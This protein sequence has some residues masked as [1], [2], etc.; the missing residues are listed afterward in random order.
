MKDLTPKF[1]KKPCN[2]SLKV[3]AHFEPLK[4]D[5][6]DETLDILASI[7]SDHIQGDAKSD[8]KEGSTSCRLRKNKHG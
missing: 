7:I 3:S 4:A 1:S 6:L 8:R 2:N 5:M